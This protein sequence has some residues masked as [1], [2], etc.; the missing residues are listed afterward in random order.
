MIYLLILKIPSND[1]RVNIS[2]IQ[3]CIKYLGLLYSIE[4]G[5][6]VGVQKEKGMGRGSSINDRKVLTFPQTEGGGGVRQPL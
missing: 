5:L 6:Y 1:G 4:S 3:L 2:A